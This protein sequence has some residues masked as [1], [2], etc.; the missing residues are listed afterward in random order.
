MNPPEPFSV[1]D[2]D[3]RSSVILHVPH[4]ATV[5]PGWV[6]DRIVLDDAALAVELGHMTDAGTD[7]VAID[8]AAR[9][10]LRP[11]LLVNRLSRLVVDPERFPDEREEMRQVG[12]GAVYSRTSHG[13]ELRLTDPAHEHD[14][15]E[16]FFHPYAQ[17]ITTLVEQ[18]LAATGRAVI[19]DVHSYPHDRLPYELHPRR[20]RPAVCLGV[21]E[22][23]TPSWL[24]AAATDALAPLGDVLVN[25]PFAGTYVPLRHYEAADL[26]VSSV[27]VEL[28]RTAA[29]V[30]SAPSPPLP[31]TA[32]DRLAE[33]VDAAG[34][35]TVDA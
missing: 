13:E 15:L 11:W 17:A 9:A 31:A 2:G 10:A 16:A 27:M 34:S 23:H 8:A 18:R 28:R 4:S 7:A 25:E 3:P 1:V 26:R 20:R 12:M 33:L 30:S 14:L 24:L 6:R 32:A 21:D 22:R 29:L 5:I 19:I 35:P